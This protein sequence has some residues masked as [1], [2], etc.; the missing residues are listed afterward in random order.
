MVKKLVV[1]LLVL[2]A[3]S[4]AKASVD[5]SEWSD[6]IPEVKQGIAFSLLD[7]KVNYLSTIE[8]AKFKNVTFELGYAGKVRNTGDKVV[9]VLSY[10]IVNLK[11]LGVDMPILDLVSLNIGAYAGVGRVQLEDTDGGNEFDAGL[12]LTI[13]DIKF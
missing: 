9:G 7:N 5:L 10:P 6:K 13:I 12:S 8:V 2:M 1:A 4:T 3:C 11:D